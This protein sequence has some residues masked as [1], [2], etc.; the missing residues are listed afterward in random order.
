MSALLLINFLGELGVLLC[1]I[2][3][4]LGLPGLLAW[5]FKKS[6]LGHHEALTLFLGF[7][8]ALGLVQALCQHF[9][10]NNLWCQSLWDL[11]IIVFIIPAFARADHWFA[12][13]VT[14]IFSAVWYFHFKPGGNFY[15]FDGFFHPALC[16]VVAL[17]I[18]SAIIRNCGRCDIVE[19][20]PV[21]GSMFIGMIIDVY[22]YSMST[23]ELLKH[24]MSLFVVR[25]FIWCVIYLIMAH[26]LYR[27][28]FSGKSL[29]PVFI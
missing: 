26:D 27:R 25:N 4:A 3:F 20:L 2:G 10:K 15:K 7:S 18:D 21:A 16:I 24:G 12:K 1:F 14:I 17:L 28:N 29:T 19:L 6:S 11:A 22:P 9:G 13:I 23:E 8:G 5:K